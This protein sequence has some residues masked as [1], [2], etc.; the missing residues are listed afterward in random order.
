MT[1]VAIIIATL[2]MLE[3]M[4]LHSIVVHSEEGNTTFAV[5]T[6]VLLL[7]ASTIF[8]LV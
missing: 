4:T 1:I 3:A 8:A 5:L 6:L 2:C 7:I